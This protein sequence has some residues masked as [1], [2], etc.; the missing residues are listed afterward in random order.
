MSRTKKFFY[1][2]LFAAI[3]QIIIL[4]VGFITPKI[5]LSVYGSEINGLVSSIT[6]FIYYFS[7]VEAGLSGAAIF[8][9]YKPLAEKDSLKIS[10]IISA[11]QKL[12]VQSGI[13]F[14]IL[15]GGL[16]II[17]PFFVECEGLSMMQIGALSLVLGTSGLLEFFTLGKYRALLTA[18]QELYVISFASIIYQILTV[19]IIAILSF[20]QCNIVIVR[21]A[22]LSAVF[23]RSFILY[24]YVKRHYSYIDYHAKPC[25]SALYKRWDA[26][27]LQ[28]LGAVH[29][30]CPVILAT[31]F[32]NLL[33]VSVY[34]IYN[35]VLTGIGGIVGIFTNG[36]SSSFGEIIAQNEENTLKAIYDEFEFAYYTLIT[37]FYSVTG[38]TIL[39]FI[40][41]YTRNIHD[42]NY[43]FPS[44]AML[45]TLNGFLY[46]LKTPQGML[47]ISA[48]HYKET[49]IQTTL[50]GLIAIIG[51][52]FLAP[53]WGLQG[54]LI[55]SILSNFYRC[56]DLLFYVSHKIVKITI[57]RTLRR[58]VFSILEFT[59]I[60]ILASKFII[61][62][63]S[64]IEWIIAALGTTLL[65][66]LVI[67]SIGFCYDRQ[68]FCSIMIRLKQILMKKG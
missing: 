43:I 7:L 48:G 62:I 8:A 11:T 51:G 53:K 27:Y 40:R 52:I 42:T 33:S 30:G 47:V 61:S 57:Y 39:S 44:L 10:S 49:K 65:A 12:Y 19:T 24:I 36:L 17:Y 18:N 22:S 66:S 68:Q 4:V 26:L 45:F 54:I 5:M 32:T 23:V 35:M 13:I 41:L 29:S 58:M 16:I 28:I 6:Q 25:K 20:A 15:L 56:I 1:N 60:V 63:N 9:L 64:Y 37:I 59:A 50:Q 67:F 55:G 3:Y 2:S 21:A 34:S 46:N 38:V 31:I 14:S